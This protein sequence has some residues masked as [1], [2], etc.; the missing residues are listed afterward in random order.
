[1]VQEMAWHQLDE[2]LGSKLIHL[3]IY[4]YLGINEL[5]MIGAYYVTHMHS[6][7]SNA[8]LWTIDINVSG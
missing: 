1:M 4:L 6:D 5:N 3:C 8:Y 7:S 2:N